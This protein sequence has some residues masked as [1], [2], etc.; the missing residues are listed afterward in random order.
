[1]LYLL[2]LL[3]GFFPLI[4]GAD[5]LVDNASSLAKRLNIPNI[6]IGLTI[7]GFGTSSPEM[8]VNIFAS[9]EKSSD[10]VLGNIIGSNLFNTLTILG[11]TAVIFPIMVRKNTTW[12]E[13]PLSLLAAV[14][15]ALMANDILID[16]SGSSVVTRTEGFILLLF[17]AIFLA[18]NIHLTLS[19]G[20]TGDVEVTDKPVPRALLILFAGLL[21]LILGGRLIVFSAIKVASLIGLSERVI[22][23]TVVSVGTSLPELVTSVVAARKKNTDIAI[24]NVIGS[25]I[26]NIFLVL[27]LSAVVNPVRVQPMANLDLLLNVAASLMLFIFV[28]TGRE[29]KIHRPEGIVFL[30]IYT[31]YVTYLV[32]N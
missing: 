23:L 16:G 3:A 13:I 2:L 8:V 1:M 7:V 18:Y 26:Y 12:T 9:F 21:M 28:F 14:V 6:V 20:Y 27:G 4:Y 32:I 15:V 22:A 30:I 31:A 19:E 10:L 24:G 17:F 25:N 11:I 29:R 5:L